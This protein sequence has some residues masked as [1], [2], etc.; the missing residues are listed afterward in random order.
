MAGKTTYK[1]VFWSQILWMIVV[2]CF[3]ILPI[4]FEYVDAESRALYVYIYYI[5]S[6]FGLIGAQIAYCFPIGSL[7][8]TSKKGYLIGLIVLIALVM[9]WIIQGR[10]IILDFSSISRGNIFPALII[11]IAIPAIQAFIHIVY[12]S[13]EGSRS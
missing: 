7:V 9:D 1:R 4:K 5:L 11:A 6:V 13:H 2:S 10:S 8:I 3:T 12:T